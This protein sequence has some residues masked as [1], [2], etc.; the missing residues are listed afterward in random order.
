MIRPIVVVVGEDEEDGVHERY[1]LRIYVL[2][3]R[4]FFLSF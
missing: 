4:R 2:A 1:D 3:P